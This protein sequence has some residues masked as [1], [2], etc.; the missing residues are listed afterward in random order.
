VQCC[1]G[2][3]LAALPCQL[4]ALLGRVLLG[5]A[6]HHNMQMISWDDSGAY[7]CHTSYKQQVTGDPA[8]TREPHAAVIPALTKLNYF[9]E[10]EVYQN[11][12]RWLTG[13]R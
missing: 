8:V 5:E 1:L 4:K 11:S 10:P 2:D 3:L 6:R 13:L 9:S 7:A 12:D